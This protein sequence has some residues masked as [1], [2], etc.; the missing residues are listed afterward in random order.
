MEIPLGS[1]APA[2]TQSDCWTATILFIQE[3]PQMKLDR[4]EKWAKRRILLFFSS[5]AS[6]DVYTQGLSILKGL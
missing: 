4:E 3:V 5:L 6:E 2:Y 1:G